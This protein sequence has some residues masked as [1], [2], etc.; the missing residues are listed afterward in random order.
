MSAT[1]CWRRLLPEE[2]EE[3]AKKQAERKAKEDARGAA[4]AAGVPADDEAVA[5]LLDSLDGSSKGPV[6]RTDGKPP[7][8]VGDLFVGHTLRPI[9]G[10][11]FS[12]RHPQSCG[13]GS[14]G[15]G[16]RS[17]E[18]RARGSAARTSHEHWPRWRTRSRRWRRSCASGRRCLERCMSPSIARRCRSISGTDCDPYVEITFDH[19]GEKTEHKT[20]V[21]RQTR[22]PVWTDDNNYELQALYASADSTGGAGLSPVE[23]WATM[24]LRVF[25]HDRLSEDDYIGG[26]KVDLVPYIEGSEQPLGG[27]E[28]EGDEERLMGQ[29]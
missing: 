27:D 4:E 7:G 13:G 16:Q 26:A 24:M 10:A 6:A 21:Q 5:K 2:A 17:D 11:S 18:R 29:E 20:P 9:G 14:R 19:H 12:G 22:K 25:D 8:H 3:R 23:S 28:D 15:R 1:S